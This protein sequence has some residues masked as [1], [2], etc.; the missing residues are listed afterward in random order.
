MR[1]S[2]GMAIKMESIELMRNNKLTYREIAG[3]L[4]ITPQYAMVLKSKHD[5]E[6]KEK[7]HAERRKYKAENVNSCMPDKPMLTV[8]HEKRCYLHTKCPV[9]E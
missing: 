7:E 5:I 4:N 3:Q 8:C 9:F 6:I 1:V 2:N